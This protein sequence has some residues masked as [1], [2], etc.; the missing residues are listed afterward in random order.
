MTRSLLLQSPSGAPRGA[1]SARPPARSVSDDPEQ[2]LQVEASPGLARSVPA[3]Q[4]PL[5]GRFLAAGAPS[6]AISLRTFGRARG[7]P[8]TPHLLRF[9]AEEGGDPEVADRIE[10]AAAGSADEAQEP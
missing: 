10:E 6:P 8:R 1:H 7:P 5:L 3:A 9:R 2:N 4:T